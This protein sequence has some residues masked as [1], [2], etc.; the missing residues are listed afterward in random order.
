ML[1]LWGALS[2]VESDGQQT[3]GKEKMCC[4][5]QQGKFSYLALGSSPD[6]EGLLVQSFSL[7]DLI[8]SFLELLLCG[9]REPLVTESIPASWK[10]PINFVQVK[11]EV[12]AG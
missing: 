3:V 1:Q 5:G 4:V 6:L 2:V 8:Q 10:Q 12:L 7:P 11:E 9:H